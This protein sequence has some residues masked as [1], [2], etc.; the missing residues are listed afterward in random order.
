MTEIALVTGAARGIGREVAR[1]LAELGFHVVLAGRDLASTRTAAEEVGGTPVRLD[2]TSADDVAGVVAVIEGLGRLD[3]LV[4]NAG[5][6]PDFDDTVLTAELDA[7]ET[8]W[9]TNL[10]GPWRLIQALAPSLRRSANPRVVNVTAGTGAHGDEKSGL[11][12]VA[13]MPAYAVTKAA[14][15]ALTHKLSV[16]FPQARV[17]AVDPGQT[18]SASGM[19]EPGF[20]PVADGAASVVWAARLGPDGPTGG[21]FRDGR[22]R[23]W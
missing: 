1:Q 21:F 10:L 15:G 11:G 19:D 17:N 20:R 13:T 3:V 7:V 6:A 4:N 12:T 14:F 16:E 18:A 5:T 2:V 22:P 8:A 9:R 23:P